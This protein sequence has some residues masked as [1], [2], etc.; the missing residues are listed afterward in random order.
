MISPH[1]TVDSLKDQ[2]VE[3]TRKTNKN[4][5]LIFQGNILMN[6]HLVEEYHLEP[7]CVLLVIDQEQNLSNCA[8]V[9][10]EIIVPVLDFFEGYGQGIYSYEVQ[11]QFRK[12]LIAIS[13]LQAIV[14]IISGLMSYFYS[15]YLYT[16]LC[17]L[18]CVLCVF[19]HIASYCPSPT[20][21][22]WIKSLMIFMILIQ[23]G[24]SLWFFI[25]QLFPSFFITV[26]LLQYTLSL[27]MP[28]IT[29][30]SCL[31]IIDRINR[32]VTNSLFDRGSNL[33]EDSL[34]GFMG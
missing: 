24:T 33:S 27:V 23:A 18:G 21:I 10:V 16:C 12:T 1:M 9:P 7:K 8:Y 11:K 20:L 19:I 25:N 4:F 26:E 31:L 17:V 13:I 2:I 22:K 28:V 3:T 15:I 14:Y 5:R 6:D 34:G 29:G 30:L 32:N